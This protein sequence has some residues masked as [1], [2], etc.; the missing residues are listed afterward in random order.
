MPDVPSLA[1]GTGLVSPLELTT[2]FAV[3]PNGGLAVRPRGIARVVDA[4]G[5]VAFD[6][7]VHAERVIS[8]ETAYQMVAMLSDVLD[9]G[10]GAA[11][12]RWGVQFPAG[13]KTGT[14]DDFKDAWFVG[15]S[16]SSVVGVWVGFDRPTT[17][18]REAYGSRYALPIWSDFMR[19]ASRV[20]RPGTFA[21]PEGLREEPLCRISYLRPVEGCPEYTEY[22]KPGD[23]VPG[24]LCDVHRGTVKQRVRR[25]VDSLISILGRRLR[26][27]VR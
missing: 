20:R 6:Q 12:R 1:L 2:A 21:V 24:Q 27:L 26:E 16:S 3:F 25:A 14:T 8:A 13:G 11:A 4:D 15:F 5:A 10:T 7:H 9:R 17:I 19:R 22:F 18:G 23:P